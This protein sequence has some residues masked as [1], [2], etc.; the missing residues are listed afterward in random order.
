[1]VIIKLILCSVFVVF[2][3]TSCAQN[4]SMALPVVEDYYTEV[5]VI[6]KKD[7]KIGVVAGPYGDMFL[8]A[9]APSLIQKGYTVEIVLYNDYV[10]PNL[11]L[12]DN[13]IDLNIFQHYTYLN[14]FKFEHDLTLSA[15]AQIPTVSMGVF[16][17]KYKSID[18]IAD[19]ATISIPGDSTNLSR[20]LRVLDAAHI[21][22]IDPSVDKSKATEADLIKNPKALQ[23][24]LVEAHMLA[25]SLNEYD[26]S[27]INGN[28]AYGEGL[29]L[30]EALFTEVLSEG[31]M[32]VIV[33]R[34]EDLNMRFV[35]DII[36]A[37]H[38]EEFINTIIDA[39]GKYSGFQRPRGF[40]KTNNQ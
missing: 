20:A 31:Y 17:M 11:A 13:E 30:S 1:M 12:A 36:D 6:E 29:N 24:S 32:N 7:L 9:I 38:S 8:D 27:V 23:F 2:I 3:F 10:Q 28:Y 5:E 25:Q 34:A 18:E 40:L 39:N 35:W 4:E 19:G 26:L 33:V 14:N 21:V 37:V 16:S 22:T 15:I